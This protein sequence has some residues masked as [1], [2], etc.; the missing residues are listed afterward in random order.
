MTNPVFSIPEHRMD[1]FAT[2]IKKLNKKAKKIGLPEIKC[3]TVGE[4]DNLYSTHPVTGVE[5]LT[6][7]LIHFFDI[8][9]D[10]IEPKYADWSFLARI[11]HEPMNINII[12]SIPGVELNE[13]YRSMGNVCEHCRINRYRKASYVVRHVEG[14]EKQVGSTCIKDFLGHGSPENIAAYCESIF[15]FMKEIREDDYFFGGH[16]EERHNIKNLLAVTSAVIRNH[17]WT[18]STKAYD[19]G[20][21]STAQLIRAY[22][23]RSDN[24]ETRE[25]RET[26]APTADDN[27]LAENSITWIVEK[28]GTLNDYLYNLKAI[29]AMESVTDKHLNIAVS[30]IPTYKREVEKTALANATKTNDPSSWI[31]HPDTGRMTVNAVKVLGHNAIESAYGITY[32]YR[33]LA[34]G[35]DKLTWFSS[36]N[37]NLE[38]GD[39][40]NITFSV[41]KLDTYKDEH[42]TIIT[43][44]KFNIVENKQE[45]AA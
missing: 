1:E 24:K 40:V 37:Q 15:S 10:G 11:D 26:C 19:T 4:H 9:I 8:S 43:R 38:Q 44:A 5:L 17:G 23:G 22:Y 21:T 6:P 7:L 45:K 34:N 31:G 28:D 20:E 32:I 36:N 39:I 42:I 3:N 33:F 35:K 30:L 13:R 29:C 14:E 27:A 16:I 25:L 12:N 41:K 2:K 18:S